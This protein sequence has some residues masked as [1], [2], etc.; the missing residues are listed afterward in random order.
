MLLLL[1]LLFFAACIYLSHRYVTPI[2]R[3]LSSLKANERTSSN[4]PEID[5]LFDYL[6]ARDRQHEEEISRLQSENADVQRERERAE[7]TLSNL[8]AAG[9]QE[10][11]PEAY[12]LFCNN[13]CS[14]TP[15]EHEIFE[16]YLSGK[17]GNSGD[18][19]H[20]SEHHQISQPEH[21]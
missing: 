5:D 15:R 12:D 13:L 16:L 1:T 11:D 14:L 21:L 4:I 18:P 8:H 17:T 20:Q 10:I 3:G 19:V 9:L 6:A 7:S 2:Q